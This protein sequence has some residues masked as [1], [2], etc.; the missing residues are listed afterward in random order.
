M[1]FQLKHVS[2][3]VRRKLGSIALAILIFAVLAG[4]GTHLLGRPVK[5]GVSSGILTGSVLACSILCQTLRG[6]W[7]R[8][9]HPL[10]SAT[11]MRPSSQRSISSLC[12]L[13]T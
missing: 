3:S 11:S 1:A 2:I 12:T 7:L 9:I 10:R 6:R 8:S 5:Y 13:R 4:L